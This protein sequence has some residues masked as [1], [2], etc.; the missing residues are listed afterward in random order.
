VQTV[1]QKTQKFKFSESRY[2]IALAHLIYGIVLVSDDGLVEFVNQAFCDMLNLTISPSELVGLNSRELLKR[3]LP[4]CTDPEGTLSRIEA[5]LADER[6]IEGQ[7]VLMRDGRA[8]L[9]DFRPIVIDGRPG[10]RLWQ[11]QDIT[12]R[13]RHE[14]EKAAIAKHLY[15]RVKELNCLYMISSIGEIPDITMMERLTKIVNVIPPAWQYPDIACSRIIIDD[16]EIK[17]LNYQETKWKQTSDIVIDRKKAGIVEVCYLEARPESDEGPFLQQEQKLLNTIAEIVGRFVARIKTDGEL[18]KNR[19]F[20][21]DLIEH[22]G[23]LICVKDRN[24]RYTLVNRQWEKITGLKREE[25][26]GK[27]DEALFPGP[28]GR[29]FR[30]N[31]LEVMES[32]SVIHKE[33]TFE[34]GQGKRYFLSIKFPLRGDD[35]R[36]NGICGM[37]TEITDRKQAEKALQESEKKFRKLS[38]IDNL[39]QLYNSRHFFNQ[40]K[41]EI[42][43]IHRYPEP[44]ALILLDVDNFKAFNDAFGHLEGDQVLMRLGR[45]IKSCLRKTDSAYRYGGEEFIVLLPMTTNADGVR[46]AERIRTEFK[47]EKF[48]PVF[49]KAVHLTLSIGISQYRSA[50]SMQSFV[51]RVDRLMYRAKKQGKDRICDETSCG[52]DPL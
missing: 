17:T 23:A 49:E 11:H 27:T 32:E 26:I 38:I 46:I 13:M 35:G 34:D 43:R 19:L 33:E 1:K 48:S 29:Q 3:V 10:G 47:N 7:E 25:T 42:D 8:L 6:R 52:D 39:T 21:S 37:I 15:E 18:R 24:G 12:D 5:I 30:L 36:V 44:L 14:E 4:F 45:V 41:T 2:Q 16:N 20:L 31:D 40:L 50:E 28:V 51:Q 22:S 9:I